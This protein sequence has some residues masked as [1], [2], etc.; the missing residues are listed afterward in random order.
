MAEETKTEL[1]EKDITDF[2]ESTLNGIDNF[3]TK[4]KESNK[5]IAS[6]KKHIEE[7]EAELAK[8]KANQNTDELEKLRTELKEANENVV[9]I[10]EENK[11]LNAILDGSNNE[12]KACQDR[13]EELE[14]MLSSKDTE[15]ANLKAKV[16]SDKKAYEA[17]INK[18]YEDEDT[19]TNQRKT[20]ET[21]LAA[22]KDKLDNLQ[23]SFTSVQQAYN[24]LNVDYKAAKAEIE[25]LKAQMAENDK[26][27]EKLGENMELIKEA[28]KAFKFKRTMQNFDSL[29]EVFS[30][31]S[32][33]NTIVSRLMLS[34]EGQLA[35]I[36]EEQN[37][38]N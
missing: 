37:D 16:E 19:L 23:G 36:R 21:E 22:A 26:T 27:A 31:I 28:I 34:V 11:S 14:S 33:V 24:E 12:H 38:N 4:F 35:A 15:V 13:I 30:D 18:L 10:T 25:S 2:G 8:L 3:L 9:K 6:Q 1:T 7:L 5:I 32:N 29:T 17:Q 20:A